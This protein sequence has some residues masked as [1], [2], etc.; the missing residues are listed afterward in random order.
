MTLTFE[1]TLQ[2]KGPNGAW[3]FMPIPFDVAEAFG[4]RGRVAVAGIVNG[5][6]F[7]NSLMPEGD[8]THSMMFGKE[9]QSGAGAGPGDTVRVTLWKDEKQRSILPPADLQA[10]VDANAS[11][12]ALFASLTY[13]QR[14]EYVEWIEGAK[15]ATTRASRIAKAVEMLASGMKRTR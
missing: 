11:A 12:A 5:F 2:A 8:G 10:A 15:Q 3:T 13:S 9:L 6:E 4:S 1:V 7:H 14:K